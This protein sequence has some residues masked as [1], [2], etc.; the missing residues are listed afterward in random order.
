MRNS[1]RERDERIATLE[2]ENEALREDV[3]ELA[4]ENEALRDRLAA[5]EDRLARLESGQGFPAVADD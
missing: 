5:H 2:A 3:T 4:D 1:K